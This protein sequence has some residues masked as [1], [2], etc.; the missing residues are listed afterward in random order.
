M[1]LGWKQGNAEPDT[2]SSLDAL[3]SIADRKGRIQDIARI[4]GVGVATVDRVLNERGNVSPSTAEKVL[5]TARQLNTKRVLPVSHHR[6]L[7]I[8]ALLP[9]PELPLIKHMNEELARLARHMGRSAVIHRTVI[10]TDN[11]R[12][13]A[14][15]IRESQANGLI[16]YSQEDP[17][18]HK[19]IAM[20]Q[21]RETA[22]VTI[23]SDLPRSDRL[24]YAGCDPYAAGRTAG[25][26]M[27]KM[28]H[29]T[30]AVAVLC[31]CSSI[32]GHEQRRRGFAD[33]LKAH[34]PGL[35]ITDVIEGGDDSV[36]SEILLRH[37]LANRRDLVGIYNVGAANDA[38]G[39]WLRQNFDSER[40]IFIGHELTHETRPMLLDGTMALVI[41]Q[42]AEQQARFA[43][44]V[45]LHHFGHE[46]ARHLTV[47]YKSDVSFRLFTPENFVDIC[48]PP[49]PLMESHQFATF[50]GAASR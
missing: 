22:V 3:T 30:G 48:E 50:R 44:E 11:P 29:R 36:K 20:A 21:Q 17:E 6:L 41:D 10:P 13:V 32:H 42:N 8:E 15:L 23:L 5:A 37:T 38:V 35:E 18:I 40:P 19:A 24:A 16:F 33:A 1:P 47:P 39:N 45:L 25:Y 31:S 34:G 7:R 2:A 49:A 4:A 9:R 27:A 14:K 46:Q 12:A 26:F 43:V 28:A